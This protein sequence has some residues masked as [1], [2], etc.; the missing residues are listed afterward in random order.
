LNNEGKSEKELKNIGIVSCFVPFVPYCAYSNKYGEDY[1]RY[2]LKILCFIFDK[3]QVEQFQG[4]LE[5]K[6][7]NK[8]KEVKKERDITKKQRAQT[9]KNRN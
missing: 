7:G 3:I 8:N 1:T 2:K 4:L 9:G 5:N 6:E